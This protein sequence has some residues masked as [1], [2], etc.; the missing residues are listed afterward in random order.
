M[1]SSSHSWAVKWDVKEED[2]VAVQW[3][4]ATSKRNE[5]YYKGKKKNIYFDDSWSE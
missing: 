4:P 3:I 1:P 2:A 5:T